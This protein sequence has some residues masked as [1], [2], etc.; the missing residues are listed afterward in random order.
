MPRSRTG[1]LLF[2]GRTSAGR[3]NPSILYSME[4]GGSAAGL[5]GARGLGFAHGG[6]DPQPG[7]GRGGCPAAG[8][9][10]GLQSHQDYAGQYGSC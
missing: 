5:L 2:A 1:L 3:E 4:F 9:R 6:G 10:E 7:G 8:G